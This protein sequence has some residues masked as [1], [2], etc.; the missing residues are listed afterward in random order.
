MRTLR[1]FVYG[2]YVTLAVVFAA[3]AIDKWLW[4]DSKSA[5]L[6]GAIGTFSFMLADAREKNRRPANG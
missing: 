1:T 6:S 4:P 3:A 2:L 5:I